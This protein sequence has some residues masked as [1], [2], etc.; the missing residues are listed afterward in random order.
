MGS[1]P[2]IPR[3]RES[4]LTLPCSMP[5]ISGP[6]YPHRLTGRL[7]V[8]GTTATATCLSLLE[9]VRLPETRA[10]RCSFQLTVLSLLKDLRKASLP[11][12]IRYS[13]GSMLFARLPQ[14]DDLLDRG[15]HFGMRRP[16]RALEC[17]IK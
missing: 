13:S 4:A 5:P 6:T 14:I 8:I 17:F 10:C 7:V 12:K 9:P 15:K 11:I 2:N 3:M 1:L 16:T